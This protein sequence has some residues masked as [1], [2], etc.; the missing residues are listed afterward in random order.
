[1]GICCKAC[2]RMVEINEEIVQIRAGE[3]VLIQGEIDFLD[4]E[5][6]G[7]LHR[8]CFDRIIWSGTIKDLERQEADAKVM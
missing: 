4:D 3:L 6:I 8:N 7:F 1:M 2:G 5:T